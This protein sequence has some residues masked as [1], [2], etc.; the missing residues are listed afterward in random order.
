MSLFAL[1][2]LLAFVWQA[3]TATFTLPSLLSGFVIGY[4]ALWLAQPLFGDRSPY[5]VRVFRIIRLTLFFLWELLVS[6]IRV[7]WDVV[8]PTHYSNPKI[9]EMPLDVES[10]FEILLVTTLISLT[11]GTLSLDVTPDRKTL[12]VHAMFADDPDALVRELKN[13]MERMVKEVFE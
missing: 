8:T 11:P 6:S 10:D 5:F 7:A 12:I 2:I 13:G 1:N 3:L 9:V 4:G